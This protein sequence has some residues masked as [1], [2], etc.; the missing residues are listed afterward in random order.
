[1][2]AQAVYTVPELARMMGVDRFRCRRILDQVHVPIQRGKR[3]QPGLVFLSDI[4]AMAPA[5]WES[6]EEAAHLRKL[7]R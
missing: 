7:A 4:K 6:L 2:I 1:M 3:G 5:V